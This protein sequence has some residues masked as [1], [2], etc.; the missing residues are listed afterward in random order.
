MF[1]LYTLPLT[2]PAQ[3]NIQMLTAICSIVKLILWNKFSHL[4]W[5]RTVN[6]DSNHDDPIA[7]LI[8]K[9][10]TSQDDANTAI[11]LEQLSENPKSDLIRHRKG[12]S[13]FSL[14]RLHETGN[15]YF[16]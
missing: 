12:D 3:A 16:E 1:C 11:A 10:Q 15:I 14:S 7:R 8:V 5:S 6:E 13:H 2:R 9:L 4:Y